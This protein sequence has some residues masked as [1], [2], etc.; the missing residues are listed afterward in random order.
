MPNIS[1][2][3]YLVGGAVR[4]RLLGLSVAEKDWLVVG[5]SPTEMKAE[6]FRQVGKD[7]PVFLHPSTK[8]EYALART[9]RKVSEGHLGF[10]TYSGKE[11][12]LEQ[13]L[14]RRDLTINAIAETTDGQ[15]LDPCGGVA[16][17]ENRILRHVTDAFAE[18]P[19][20]VLRVARFAARFHHLG[21]TIANETLALMA[22]ISRSGELS[23][24]PAERIW[25]ETE[26]ALSTE[27][28]RV[29]FE[30]LRQCEGLVEVFPEID[31]LFGVEQRADYHPEI[32]TGLHTMLALDQ[33][34]HQTEDTRMRFATLVH[35]LGKA[36][37][38]QEFLPGHPGHEERG[39]DLVLELCK[40]LK[41]PNDYK[42]LAVR[43][44]SLHL[45]CHRALELKPSTLVKLL[46]DLDAWRSS[47]SLNGFLKC[48]VADARGR[49]GLENR[50]YP[51]SDY[52]LECA[53]SARSIDVS[54]L[55][56]KGLEGKALGDSIYRARIEVLT[57][58]KNKYAHIDEHKFSRP[59][60]PK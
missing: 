26:K 58:V 15:L 22:D 43:V 40:R 50:E 5:C 31:A 57:K 46:S 1:G 44:A 38:P 56:E 49:T 13:D 45:K 48:C 6:G 37:T 16:D 39:A 41:T 8:E 27:D 10:E 17:L 25:R 59:A 28:P 30:T 12:S 24:L 11:V 14:S 23:T 60:K 32:D 53:E 42:N 52:L 29:F 9:E 7:F 35:D 4:D 36:T 34:C 33:I 55:R 54:V 3:V 21:F 51:Q 20:R 18:D 2:Q 47:D 19:L